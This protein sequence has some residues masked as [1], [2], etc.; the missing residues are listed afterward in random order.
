MSL[1]NPSAPESSPATPAKGAAAA[2]LEAHQIGPEALKA[3]AHPLRMAILRYLHDHGTATA[4]TL[5]QHLGESTGQTSYHLRQLAK[6]GLVEDVPERG[7][8]R[9]R[10]WRSR[11]ANVGLATMLTDEST[12][13]AA[14]VLLSEML[15]ERTEALGRWLATLSSFEDPAR[16]A[17]D[18]IARSALHSQSTLLLTGDELE[19]LSELLADTITEFADRHRGRFDDG[20]PEGAVR[21][22][23]YVDVFPLA[24]DEPS[25]PS[26]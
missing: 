7:T 14:N 9:E 21:V 24:D 2:H 12:A 26:H 23:A 6:H 17:E 4:T 3:Y 19:E 22:R 10:W 5:A 13:H 8:G 20:A 18:P 15:R 1:G 25:P 16:L 11:S